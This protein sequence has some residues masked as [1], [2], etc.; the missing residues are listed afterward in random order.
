VTSLKNLYFSVY[1]AG[2]VPATGRTATTG[3]TEAAAKGAAATGATGG[4]A[5]VAAATRAA[6]GATVAAAAVATGAAAGAATGAAVA[7]VGA[8][9]D[10]RQFVIRCKSLP[11]KKT[12]FIANINTSV[13]S[14]VI[15]NVPDP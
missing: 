11:G 5:R 10:A 14:F 12:S 13:K 4:A 2:G 6:A 1:R 3:A 8:T 9:R 7:T 15:F